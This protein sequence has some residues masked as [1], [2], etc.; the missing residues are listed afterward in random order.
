MI[1]FGQGSRENLNKSAIVP[2]PGS[3]LSPQKIGEAPKY[4]MGLK[5]ED[6]SAAKRAQGIPGPGQY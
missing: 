5:L 6:V 2:G 3:Y 4:G 1:G